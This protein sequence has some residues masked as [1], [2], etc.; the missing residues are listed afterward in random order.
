MATSVNVVHAELGE[1]AQ[2]EPILLAWGPRRG[3]SGAATSFINSGIDRA[4]ATDDQKKAAI[5]ARRVKETREET[6]ARELNQL[7]L[8]TPHELEFTA[9][10]IADYGVYDKEVSDT[11][12]EILY[13]RAT[14]DDK[15][16]S[17]G[18][19]WATRALGSLGAL[20]TDRYKDILEYVAKNAKDKRTKK[21]AKADLKKLPK[22]GS[23]Q[24]VP[25]TIEVKLSIF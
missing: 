13:Q 22:T 10:E 8:K 12:A 4:K 19:A 5:E 25:G 18:L 1:L 11:L 7:S 23:E 15:K 14:K 16:Y 9:R 20:D 17:Q 6:T 3:D 21:Y 2:A 24:Y